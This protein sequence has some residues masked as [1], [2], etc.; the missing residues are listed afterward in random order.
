MNIW[1]RSTNSSDSLH[2]TEDNVVMM[3]AGGNGVSMVDSTPIHTHQHQQHHHRASLHWD[4]LSCLNPMKG[5]E[6]FEE[7]IYS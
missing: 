6:Q 4:K 5:M 3:M 2:L 7:S 1:R